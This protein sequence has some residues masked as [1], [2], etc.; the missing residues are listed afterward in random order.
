[1]AVPPSPCARAS[2]QLPPQCRE[3]VGAPGIEAHAVIED[4]HVNEQRELDGAIAGDPKQIAP[5]AVLADGVAQLK[6]ARGGKD[7]DGNVGVD[8]RLVT[9]EEAA[10]VI[11]GMQTGGEERQVELEKL[12]EQL[13]GGSATPD[14]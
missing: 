6:L 13:P 4:D 14:A 2:T 12:K 3:L 8:G 7:S 9:E 11:N 10:A 5:D 1:M